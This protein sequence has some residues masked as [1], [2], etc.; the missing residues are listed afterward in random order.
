[1]G[2]LV[3]TLR[4]KYSGTAN[5][6]CK[7]PDAGMSSGQHSDP[8]GKTRKEWQM[9]GGRIPGSDH[10]S[11]GFCS[12]CDR[13]DMENFEQNKGKS[14]VIFWGIILTVVCR[15]ELLRGRN[16]HRGGRGDE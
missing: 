4:R 14:P 9:W 16:I 12:H 5:N 8:S 10:G 2:R 6:R 3:Q 7:K 13:K 11:F 15:H 1:M